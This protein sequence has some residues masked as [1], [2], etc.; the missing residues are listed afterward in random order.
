MTSSLDTKIY[1]IIH[2]HS[3]GLDT[4]TV[5]TSVWKF[6]NTNWYEIRKYS[7]VSLCCLFSVYAVSGFSV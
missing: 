7:L 2:T 1:N 5:N 6:T 3:I 4:A